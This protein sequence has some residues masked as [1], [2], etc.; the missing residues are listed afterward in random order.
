MNRMLKASLVIARRDYLATVL[1]R[2]FIMFILS[3]LLIILIV[4]GVFYISMA[5][6][7]PQTPPRLSLIAAPEIG[8]AFADRYAALSRQLDHQ[9]FEPVVV[10]SPKGDAQAQAHGLLADTRTHSN[11]VL[12]GLPDRPMLIG[13]KA[14]LDALRGG[15]ALATQL[16][17]MPQAMPTDAPKLA[18]HNIDPAGSDLTTR[19]EALSENAKTLLFWLNML[20]A[21]RLLADLVEEKSN[22]IIEILV[23][24]VSVDAVFLGKLMANLAVALT[25][26]GAYGLLLGGGYALLAP[27]EYRMAVPAIGWPLFIPLGVA[28]FVMNYL[29]FG[30]IFLGLG[31]QA[32][33]P[34]EVQTISMPATMGQI[35]IF[36]FASAALGHGHTATWYAA[37]IFPLSSPLVM[38]AEGATSATLWPHLLALAWLALWVALIIR[39]AGNRFRKHVLKSGSV[40]A[41]VKKA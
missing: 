14:S 3:P 11:A 2:M 31:A 28:Y 32:N 26:V 39:F 23:A 7:V 22:K 13:P 27:P 17:R 4:A 9:S 35:F 37:A 5:N 41:R 20:L 38:F 25:I 24:A 8:E 33:S 1:S 18:E 29:I 6:D 16:A 19:R 10:V 21:V 12:V 34:R 36:V 30:G 15:V 40:K